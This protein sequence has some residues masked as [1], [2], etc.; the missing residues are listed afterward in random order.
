M[1]QL[2]PGRVRLARVAA[3]SGRA[4]GSL[5]PLFDTTAWQSPDSTGRL[6]VT[7]RFRARDTQPCLVDAPF[8]VFYLDV[9]VP[10]PAGERQLRFAMSAEV[11]PPGTSAAFVCSD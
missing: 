1:V 10:R 2:P 9:R 6:A 3:V 5:I 4:A 8:L 7:A 11:A